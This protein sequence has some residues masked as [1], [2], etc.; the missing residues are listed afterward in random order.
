MQTWLTLRNK[1]H[2]I[3]NSD[4]HQNNLEILSIH[5]LTSKSVKD[6]EHM[7]EENEGKM[8][9]AISYVYYLGPCISWLVTWAKIGVNSCP[10]N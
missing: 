6:F 1:L 4:I 3:Q 5:Q 8:G 9:V 10:N 7:N 2:C